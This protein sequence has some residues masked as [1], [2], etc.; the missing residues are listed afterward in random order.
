[1]KARVLF[2]QASWPFSFSF[3]FFGQL[4]IGSV[5]CGPW[6]FSSS[7]FAACLCAFVGISAPPVMAFQSV[8]LLYL[9]AESMKYFAPNGTSL[10]AQ[11]VRNWWVVPTVDQ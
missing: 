7:A 1:M 10:L 11:P 4:A 8:M 9:V 5:L 6:L 2:V 3:L